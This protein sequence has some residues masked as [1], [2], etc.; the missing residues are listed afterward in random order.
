MNKCHVRDSD[1]LW[2]L[3]KAEVIIGIL[4]PELGPLP[5]TPALKEMHTL[6]N[7]LL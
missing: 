1:G 4:I 2:S 3:G 5:S 7:D 6:T